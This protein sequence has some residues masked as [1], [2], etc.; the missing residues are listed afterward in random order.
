MG[1]RAV[2]SILGASPWMLGIIRPPRNR[3]TVGSPP[4]DVEAE[5][6]V[7]GAMLLSPVALDQLA[8][9]LVAS[10]FYVPEHRR[11]FTAVTRLR[12]QGS[13]VDVVTTTSALREEG[14]DHE[15]ASKLIELVANTPAASSG[16][17]YARTVV[18]HA[19]RRRLIGEGAAL[20]TAANDLVRDPAD[21]LENHQAVLSGIGTSILDIEP[22]DVSVEEFTNRPRDAINP[23]VVHGL[24]RRGH[25]LIMVGGEGS[26][27]SWIARFI[28]ICAAY[29]VQPFRQERTRPIRTL[30]ADF[31]NP[32]DALFDSFEAILRHVTRYNPQE[33]TVNRLWWR[34][35]GINLRNRVDLAAFENVLRVRRPD[36]VC[37]GPLY[38]SYENTS[39][40]FGWETAAREVQ[41]I[42]KRLIVRYNFALMIEDHA[43]QGDSLGKRQMRPYGSSFWRRWPDIGI[44]MEPVDGRDDLFALTR[45]RGDRVPT[46]WPTFI[47]RGNATGSPWPFL[48]RWD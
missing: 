2:E 35:Q 26:G 15:I 6:S 43:P 42:L 19:A 45:W 33:E 18:A 28:A 9:S 17:Y 38:A 4:H 37:M 12:D 24:L 7:L 32:Q 31:E 29:G 47:E 20:I 1:L 13:R 16:V 44:G 10:D 22:D 39:A 41:N 27:K 48:G 3:G 5:E 46:D 23:W 36:L 30:I 8:D 25:K 40:D 34:P 21:V 11:I 14:A